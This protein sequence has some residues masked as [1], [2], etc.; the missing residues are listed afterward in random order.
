MNS[1][2][3]SFRTI[4]G[5]IVVTSVVVL[6]SCGSGTDESVTA[7][8]AEETVAQPEPS[9]DETGDGGS[10][11]GEA[12][13]GTGTGTITTADGTVYDFTMRSCDTSENGSGTFLIEDAYDLSGSTSDGAFTFG[14]IRA[15]LEDESVPG[16]GSFEGDFDDEGKNAKMLYTN[17]GEPMELAVDGG[18]VSGTFPVRAIGPTRPHGDNTELT[19]DISC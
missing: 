11:D 10:D 2:R 12:A 9:T 5:A 13:A 1:S 18:S 4:H 8:P 6:S 15:S 14:F 3:Y 16:V 19:V 7:E 17:G